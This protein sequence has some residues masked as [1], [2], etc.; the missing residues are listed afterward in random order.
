MKNKTAVTIVLVVL[1]GIIIYLTIALDQAWQNERALDR[2][3]NH[4]SK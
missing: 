4:Y 1:L 2:I 3:L